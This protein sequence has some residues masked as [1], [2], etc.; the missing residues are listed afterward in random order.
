[1]VTQVEVVQVVGL[2]IHHCGVKI[3]LIILLV[4]ETCYGSYMVVVERV[5]VA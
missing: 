2:Y 3:L 4:V 1:M 5:V